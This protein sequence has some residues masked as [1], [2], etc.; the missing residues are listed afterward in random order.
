MTDESS[1]FTYACVV[2][3]NES[4]NLIRKKINLV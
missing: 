2:M 4:N 3:T 1:G